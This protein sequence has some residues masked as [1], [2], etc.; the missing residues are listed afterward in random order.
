MNL[1]I[2]PHFGKQ[3][4]NITDSLSRRVVQYWNKLPPMVKKSKSINS[5]KANLE[6]YKVD[7]FDSIGNYWSLSEEIFN[8]I[9][10]EHRNDHINYLMGHS[11]VAKSRYINLN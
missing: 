9:N 4:H 2:P 1:V 3:N 8:R 7:K 5:F 10:E 11:Y 6:K